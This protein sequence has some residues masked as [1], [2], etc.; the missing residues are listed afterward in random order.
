MP[1]FTTTND[2]EWSF[3][4]EDKVEVPDLPVHDPLHPTGPDVPGYLN[5]PG[6]WENYSDPIL[7]ELES[8]LRKWLESKTEDKDWAAKGAK[9]I[10]A[11]KH[12]TSMVY[13]CLYGKPW[14][15]KD[16]DCQVRMRR[17]PRLLAYYSTRIQKEGIVNGKKV[18][19]SIYHL[20]LKRYKNVPPYCLK[21]RI[22]WL[23][24][25][26]KMPVG[27]NMQLPKDDLKAGHARNPK[28]NENMRN[29]RERA[30]QR[31]NERY[32]DRKR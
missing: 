2:G 14:D 16:K 31:Y 20:S 8:L 6:K 24:K 26:G 15:P 22:E 32:G 13:M 29:R 1:G 10:R 23:R 11:R 4:F 25:H 17:L 19:K 30:R 7:Y 28:T 3:S 12:T 18:T 21:L 9:G 27:Q 5:G